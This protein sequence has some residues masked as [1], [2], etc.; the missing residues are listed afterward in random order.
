M[1]RFGDLSNEIVL[2]IS[3]FVQPPDLDS[4]YL[5]SKRIRELNESNI[6][7]HLAMKRWYQEIIHTEI[8]GFPYPH[9]GTW[10]QLLT[11]AVSSPWMAAHVEDVDIRGW[12]SRWSTRVSL[13]EIEDTRKNDTLS[14]R[15]Q[16]VF[17]TAIEQSK[18]V[19]NAESSNW[20]DGIK[21]GCEDNI[22]SLLLEVL[23]NLSNLALSMKGDDVSFRYCLTKMLVHPKS[24][25]FSNLKRVTLSSDNGPT[26]LDDLKHFAALPSMRYICA[27]D[28]TIMNR[29]T[30]PRIIKSSVTTL[31]LLSCNI[32]PEMM[33]ELLCSFH[34]LIDFEYTHATPESISNHY[35]NLVHY[36]PFWLVAA[37]KQSTKH[38]LQKLRMKGYNESPQ[39]YGPND[40]SRDLM[41]SLRPFDALE[42]VETDLELLY[43][44]ICD[45][46]TEFS[47]VLP[48][49]IR[50]VTLHHHEVDGVECR[51]VEDLV[52]GIVPPKNRALPKL[53]NL[54]FRSVDAA[55]APLPVRWRA[56]FE[57]V[58]I[59]LTSI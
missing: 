23:P 14:K 58:G 27:E 18:Y 46:N 45:L 13:A 17:A 19:P 52:K 6:E 56:A 43:G 50:K 32:V 1:A 31:R 5:T 53:E 44:G 24:T 41:G 49:S 33:F 16:D 20:S 42:E 25:T 57:A 11:I 29:V 8:G 37:L 40:E 21:T 2:L 3:N 39:S 30:N 36:K 54:H 34:S 4:F 47:E 7:L 10:A 38:S 55:P 59:T 48:E 51:M 26:H 28:I 22:L 9:T 15:G 12:H 35:N